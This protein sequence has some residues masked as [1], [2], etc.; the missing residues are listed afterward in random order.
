MYLSYDQKQVLEMA[1]NI[2]LS[3]FKDSRSVLTS[4]DLKLHAELH[5][6]KIDMAD[7]MHLY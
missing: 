6:Q 7:E 4:E 3:P 5:R 2:V 1:G